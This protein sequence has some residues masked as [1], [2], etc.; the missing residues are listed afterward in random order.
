MQLKAQ[1][2]MLNT[3][4]DIAK[5]VINDFI[6]I[7]CLMKKTRCLGVFKVLLVENKSCYH[8]DLKRSRLFQ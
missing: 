4:I 8:A 6:C 2:F 5:I 3:V 7:Y 1:D